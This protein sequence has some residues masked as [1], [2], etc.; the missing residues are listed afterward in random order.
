MAVWRPVDQPPL[1]AADITTAVV[2]E[3]FPPRYWAVCPNVSWGLLPWEADILALSP[4]NILHEIEI[5]VSIADLK[6]DLLKD[7]W[8]GMKM[9]PGAP[10][11]P[12]A[13]NR[14]TVKHRV[15][16]FWY[17]VPQA[18]LKKACDIAEEVGA[19]VIGC[20]RVQP[21]CANPGTTVAAVKA[22]R[23]TRFP[24]PEKFEP[25]ALRNQIYRLCSLRYWDGL[26]REAE[27]A[28]HTK[29]GVNP[30]DLVDPGRD[31]GGVGG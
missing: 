18:M 14:R 26:K 20:Q 12:S 25:E 4:N 15:H 2:H 10:P 16:H 27:H 29:G 21:N 17:A 24:G 28:G 3:L 30:G 5:K 1:N 31:C 22:L 11:W 19:G 8:G 13:L 23:P 6:R 7:K 9:D